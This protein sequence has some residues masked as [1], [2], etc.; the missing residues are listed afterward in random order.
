[1]PKAL[2]QLCVSPLDCLTRL[3]AH[4]WSMGLLTYSFR[5]TLGDMLSLMDVIMVYSTNHLFPGCHILLCMTRKRDTLA[6]LCILL[7]IPN[8]YLLLY[9]LVRR[10]RFK[11]LTT[12]ATNSKKIRHVNCSF[13]AGMTDFFCYPMEGNDGWEGGNILT[14]AA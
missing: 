6:E 4:C 14:V 10:K 3:T 5:S 1:M 7:H 9:N 12:E 2:A 13:T 8:P 11:Y